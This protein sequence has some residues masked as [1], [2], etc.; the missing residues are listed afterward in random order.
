M[1]TRQLIVN[2]VETPAA[3]GRT[4]P[5]HSPWSGE[6][7][8]Q[9]AAATPA[10]V[11]R[12]TEAAQDAFPA[13]AAAKPSERRA[14]L[15]KA[16]D[17]L[18]KRAEQV[19]ELISAETGGTR[20]W[21]LFNVDLASQILREA[22]AATTQPVGEVLSS[23]FTG[24]LSLAVREPV[25]VVAA[26]SP[27]NAPVILGVRSLAVPLAVGN[28]V[29]LKPSEDAPIAAGYFLADL[30]HE[31]G[32]PPG[33][34]NV[35]SN[36][37]EDAAEIARTLIADQ[38]VRMVNFTGSTGVGRIIG[39]TAAEHLKPAVLELGGKN[40]VLV[41]DDADLDQAA[42]A[43][44]FGAFANTGQ[45]CMSADRVLVHRAV[46][47]EFTAKLTARAATLHPGAPADPAT[48]LGPL[49]SAESAQ[50][51]AALVAETVEAGATLHTGGGPAQGASYPATVLSGIT[52]RM[53]IQH[54]EVFGPVCTVLTFDTDEEAVALANNT[55]YGLSTG[56]LTGHQG[57]GLAIARQLRTGIAH[58]G[59]Q[60]VADEPQAPFGGVG[61]SGYGKF[62]GRWGVDAFTTTRWITV[63][64]QHSQYPI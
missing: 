31:A 12:A 58:V 62:G 16:A 22:A 5:D 54:E 57:R 27:W 7:Y 29:V 51:V 41:L 45:I 2:G 15:L 56:I 30:L 38:R 42:A 63:G 3:S 55:G 34:L 49:I 35:V 24:Q 61:Q 1:R 43:V 14:V 4:A 23:E 48:T 9:V 33:V 53:R 20:G 46:A 60:S 10:D 52:P 17:L 44:N 40:S 8:A 25:G 59:D 6:V 50:R 19:V 32:L 21:A 18:E 26:F 47:E 37:R 11:T 39:V 13:W 36:A 64:P 28:T